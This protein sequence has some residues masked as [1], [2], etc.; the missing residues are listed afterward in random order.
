MLDKDILVIID[1][2]EL[3]KENMWNICLEQAKSMDVVIQDIIKTTYNAVNG[4][5]YAPHYNNFIYKNI[6]T[7]SYF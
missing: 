2:A 1:E 4:I 6:K 5:N 3:F 7:G